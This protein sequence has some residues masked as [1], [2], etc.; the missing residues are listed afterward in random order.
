MKVLRSLTARGSIALPAAPSVSGLTGAPRHPVAGDAGLS[1]ELLKFAF[2]RCPRT[3]VVPPLGYLLRR[4][5]TFSHFANLTAAATRRT[6]G[7]VAPE[8]HRL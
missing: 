5:D 7:R 3:M 4:D 2:T 6:A 8:H 1:L